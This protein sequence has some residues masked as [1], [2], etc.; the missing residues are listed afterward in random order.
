MNLTRR[1]VKVVKAILASGEEFFTIKDAS[2]WSGLSYSNTQAT[3]N[4][5]RLKGVVERLGGKANGRI[6]KLV[7]SSAEK[8]KIMKGV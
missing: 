4:N 8:E 6:N 1:E 3:L 5:L 2:G 7:L